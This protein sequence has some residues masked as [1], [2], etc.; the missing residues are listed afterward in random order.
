MQVPFLDLKAQYTTLRPDVYEAIGRVLNSCAF[1]GGPE[2]EAFEKA[3][4]SY[5]EVD[6]CIGV[7]SGTGALELILR[8][9]EIGPGDDV[10]TVANT[11]FAT[12]EAI[13]LVGARPVLI[14]ADEGTALMDPKLLEKAITPQTKAVIPVHLFG[15]PA[16]MD[17][18]LEIARKHQLIV[19]EDSCQAHGA[20]YKGRKTGSLADSAAFSFYPGK[21]LGAYGEAGA[22]T[23]NDPHIAERVRM[24]RDHGMPR[25]YQHELVGRNDRMDGIQGAVLVVKL[26]HLD[27]WNEARRRHAA[28]YRSLLGDCDRIQL[29]KEREDSQLVYHLFVARVPDRDRVLS[30]L[31]EAGIATGIHY[32]IPIHLQRAYEHLGYKE[33]RF[34]V[35]ETLALEII[36]L[37]MFAELTQEQICFV[38][39]TLKRVV[40]GSDL[41]IA[42]GAGIQR[43]VHT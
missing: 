3:F 41:P 14:D 10:I 37:P 19:I 4:A 11:F 34:P 39:D 26:K 7:G 24:L 31:K 6:E 42:A 23:T 2:V 5:C 32:P 15:Q 33:G 22:I 25:K 17:P 21:N 9:Y 12:A 8:A 36:S 28:Q 13:S 20:M 18:I 30:E 38:A 40:Y 35:S 27:Q 43:A 29:I 16:D 1:A